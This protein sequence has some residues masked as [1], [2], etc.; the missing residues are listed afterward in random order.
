MRTRLQLYFS[1]I[2]CSILSFKQLDHSSCYWISQIYSSCF[3]RTFTCDLHY[4]NGGQCNRLHM[5]VK[6]TYVHESTVTTSLYKYCVGFLT[7]GQL[8]SLTN[9]EVL[10]HVY[11]YIWYRRSVAESVHTNTYGNS[12]YMLR[13]TLLDI[14]LEQFKNNTQG[15]G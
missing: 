12:C 11:N 1:N 14:M 13:K 9:Q 5:I 8:C 7:T 3:K 2:Q 10:I 4:I 15:R 6:Q